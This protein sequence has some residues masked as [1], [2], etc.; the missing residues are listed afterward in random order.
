[1]YGVSCNLSTRAQWVVR[2]NVTFYHGGA[3]GVAL[4]GI[5]VAGRA[6]R[7]HCHQHRR[8]GGAALLPALAGASP[9][10]T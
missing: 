3:A 9:A 8:R 7:Q 4:A 10:P 6:R 5:A 2:P 1:M